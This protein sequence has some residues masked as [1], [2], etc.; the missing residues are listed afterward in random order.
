MRIL[1]ENDRPID[2]N[3]VLTDR[4][5][6]FKVHSAIRTQRREQDKQVC[7]SI[8]NGNISTS[9][10]RSLT[11]QQPLEQNAHYGM[12]M[13]S[14]NLAI[15]K[16]WTN[17]AL[18]RIE[19][20]RATRLFLFAADSELPYDVWLSHGVQISLLFTQRMAKIFYWKVFSRWQRCSVVET[21]WITKMH[22]CGSFL[23]FILVNLPVRKYFQK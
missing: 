7:H 16:S 18:V 19:N 17:R 10:D 14:M 6:S 13:R 2:L 23:R 21:L 15:A 1:T 22:S 3:R 20:S 9:F 8:E 4:S 5:D 12:P 11:D